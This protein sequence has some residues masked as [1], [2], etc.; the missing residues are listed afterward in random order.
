MTA[1]RLSADGTAIT[2][3]R[4]LEKAL[5]EMGEPTLG[6]LDGDTFCYLVNSP[7]G[8][9]DKEGTFIPEKAAQPIIRSLDLGKVLAS[10]KK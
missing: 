1:Y 9:Y 5:P 10:A 6:Y 8:A 2:E 7:W 4:Y 3:F